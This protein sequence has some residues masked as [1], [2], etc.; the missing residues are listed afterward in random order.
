GVEGGGAAPKPAS[1]PAAARP[2]AEDGIA[3]PSRP[4][5]PGLKAAPKPPPPPV[6]AEE[7]IAAGPP[8]RKRRPPTPANEAG[9]VEVVED[10]P[11]DEPEAPR[12]KRK[13]KRRR[14]EKGFDPD[15]M[16]VYIGLGLVGAV[17]L[18]LTLTAI[19]FPRSGFLLLVI[20]G[21]IM[22]GI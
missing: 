13:K 4:P 15:T 18:G 19:M 8:P 3:T 22:A 16:V 17:Y 9:E 14:E 1:K 20:M 21:A 2:L 10:E 11:A 7:G 12:R 6:P 5:K